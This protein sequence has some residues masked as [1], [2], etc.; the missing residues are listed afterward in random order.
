MPRE[1]LF[2]NTMIKLKI[3]FTNIPDRCGTFLSVN[4][5]DMQYEHS[6]SRRVK[7]FSA[8]VLLLELTMNA[9]RMAICRLGM[10]LAA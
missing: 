3:F 10:V 6:T 1:L 8:G 7:I 2:C 9:P 5:L 4:N